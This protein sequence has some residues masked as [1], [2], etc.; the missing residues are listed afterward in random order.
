MTD[1]EIRPV[2]ADEL[3]AVAGL[4]WRWE[5][6]H[7]PEPLVPEDE[8]VRYFVRWSRLNA[9]S[10]HCLVAVRE[11][12]VIGMAWLAVTARVP[13]PMSLERAVGDLQSVYLVSEERGSGLGSRLVQAVMTHAEEAGLMQVTVHSGSRAIPMYVRQGF[14]ASPKLMMAYGRTHVRSR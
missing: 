10:H 11:G 7:T 1:V 8:F 13:T 14:E 12:T 2:R 5:L 3:E 9:D 4:R 6:E